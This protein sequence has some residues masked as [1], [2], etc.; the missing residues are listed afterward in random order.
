MDNTLPQSVRGNILI[1]DDNP[2]NLDMLT[3][4][5]IKHNYEGRA[6]VSASM[7]LTAIH[8]ELPDLILLDINMPEMNGYELCEHLKA[9]EETRHIPVIF[10]SAL[11]ETI[12]K[13]RAFKVGGVDYLIKPIQ[14]DELLAR[15]EAHLTLSRQRR[16]L[17]QQRTEIEMLRKRDKLYFDKLNQ[18]RDEFISTASH[19]LKNPIGIVKG[20]ADLIE[21]GGNVLDPETLD[22]LTRIKRGADRM[23]FLVNDLLDLSKIETGLAVEPAPVSLRTFLADCVDN[24]K[25]PVKQKQLKLNF[26]PPPESLT[27]YLDARRM[28]Q[29]FSNLLSNA[30]KY[31][32]KGGTVGV[33]TE[34]KQDRV[35]V[36][37][38]DTGLGIPAESIPHLFD[39]FYRVPLESHM[40]SEGTGLGLAIVRAIIEQHQGWISVES[41]LG[42]GSVFHVNLPLFSPGSANF[43]I[44]QGRVPALQN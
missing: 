2:A 43:G 28:Y 34:I 18:T 1:V 20:Y 7:A 41:E 8:A 26:V 5:L 19:D 16:E 40:A 13:V 23:L 24:F 31:T 4:M 22:Y 36:H 32:P 39:K 35:I 29:V 37:M 33:E 15:I 11:G 14:F 30:I 12:D 3:S 10:V 9:N 38:L 6:V 27:A 42:V 44:N 25:L 21:H 17:D